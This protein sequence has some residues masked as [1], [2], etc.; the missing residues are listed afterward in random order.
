MAPAQGYKVYVAP[1]GLMS[2]FW[3][4]YDDGNHMWDCV[5][6]CGINLSIH[7]ISVILLLIHL[8][9]VMKKYILCIINPE[10][11]TINFYFWMSFVNKTLNAATAVSYTHLDVYKRQLLY[12][13]LYSIV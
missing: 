9:R 2:H 1:L 7:F 8:S 5:Y 13:V 4:N 12:I 10:D 11:F 3:K 6:L